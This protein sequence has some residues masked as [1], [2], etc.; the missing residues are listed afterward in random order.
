MNGPPKRHLETH[1]IVTEL[2]VLDDKL[3]A[4]EALLEA[5]RALPDKWRNITSGNT[6]YEG[7]WSDGQH[8]SANE[9]ETALKSIIK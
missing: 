3:W 1:N 6:V 9:L 2:V 7:G 4:C 5:V 8:T